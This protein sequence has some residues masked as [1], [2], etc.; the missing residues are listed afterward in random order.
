[1]AFISWIV[2]RLN[3]AANFFYALYLECYYAYYIPDAVA[4]L[5]YSLVRVFN[6]LAWDFSDFFSWLLTQTARLDEFLTELDIYNAF[7]YQ[8][9]RAISAW[10]WVK[11]AW[12][13]VTNIIEAWWL[14]TTSTVQSWIDIAKQTL[15]SQVDNLASQVASLQGAMSNLLEML[16]SLNEV[17]SWFSDWWSSTLTRIIAWGAL[18][19][20]QIQ[21][22]ID[23]TLKSYQPFW[24]G[25]QE[26]RDKVI[27]FFTDPED[28]LYKAM[29]RIIERFW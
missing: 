21:S 17:V 5:F 15:Q 29:D 2:E 25:W 8:F 27:E 23:S 7:K 20:L 11:G 1:M 4:E 9:D 16:P 10:E 26:W 24:E 14:G 18:T 22:L 3:D 13:N 28:W 6:H 19:A 12:L